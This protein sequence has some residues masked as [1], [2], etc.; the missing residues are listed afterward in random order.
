MEN[1]ELFQVIEQLKKTLSDVASA[2]KQ[3]EDTIASSKSIADGFQNASKS[4]DDLSGGVHK[5]MDV[6]NDERLDSLANLKAAVNGLSK[7]CDD[8]VASFGKQCAESTKALSIQIESLKTSIDWLSSFQ[9]SLT[10]AVSQ[11]KALNDGINS[12]A[13]NLDASQQ[14]QD[15]AIQQIQDSLPEIKS[16]LGS[17]IKENSSELKVVNGLVSDS[18][19]KL[20]SAIDSVQTRLGRRTN[21]ILA[22]GVISLILLI[23]VLLK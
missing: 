3:V 12:L 11:I 19:A 18:N 22:L 21:I 4:F 15:A 9:N 23:L 10:D 17:L 14:A 1:N 5:L 13:Q 16:E 2:R 20:Q 7:S 6:A 8:A